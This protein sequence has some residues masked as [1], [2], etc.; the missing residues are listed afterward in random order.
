MATGGK[1]LE[2][3]YEYEERTNSTT[4]SKLFQET[5]SKCSYGC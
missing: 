4:Y 5:H 1:G 2:G 3:L